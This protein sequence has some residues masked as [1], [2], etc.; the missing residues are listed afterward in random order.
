MYRISM[1]V[2]I[3]EK[4]DDNSLHMIGMPH[5]TALLGESMKFGIQE[6]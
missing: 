6:F 2:A 5:R 4:V 1:S 3:F